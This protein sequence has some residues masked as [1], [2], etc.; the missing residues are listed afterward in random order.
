MIEVFKTN[1][2]HRDHA[3]V[4]IEQIHESFSDYTANFD[5]EDCDKI[6]RV[7]CSTGEIEPAQLIRLLREFGFNA[8]VLEDN[9]PSISQETTCWFIR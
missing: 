7:K 6:L 2:K 8:E 5:L 3:N 9:L 4:L 1:V